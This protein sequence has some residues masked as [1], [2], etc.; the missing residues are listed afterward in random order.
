L[1]IWLPDSGQ[2]LPKWHQ[3]NLT[4][5]TASAVGESPT[6]GFKL[7]FRLIQ[8]PAASTVVIMTIV[9]NKNRLTVSVMVI[10][11]IT[12]NQ[13]RLAASCLCNTGN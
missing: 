6:T 12:D 8:H 5:L 3:L 13:T 4:R 11:T 1:L 10:M 7:A 9:E 2:L